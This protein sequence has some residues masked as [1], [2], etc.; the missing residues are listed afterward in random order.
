[1]TRFPRSIALIPAKALARYLL[2]DVL[3]R[4]ENYQSAVPQ[5]LTDWRDV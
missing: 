2:A 5:F 3:L 1:M 4:E